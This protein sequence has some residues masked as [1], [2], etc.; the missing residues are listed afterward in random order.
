MVIGMFTS[1]F[2][3]RKITKDTDE[4]ILVNSNILLEL[5]SIGSCHGNYI[6]DKNLILKFWK[7][8]F[9]NEQ[10]GEENNTRLKFIKVPV[11]SQTG[12]VDCGVFACYFIYQYLLSNPIT[13]DDLESIKFDY[14]DA[15]NMRYFIL[16]N[17]N[18]IVKDDIERKEMIIDFI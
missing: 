4:N 14:D 15:V 8:K 10:I 7:N 13:L 2:P 11:V 16:F 17:F 6:E 3:K 18:E 5:N 9:P 1:F 12:S